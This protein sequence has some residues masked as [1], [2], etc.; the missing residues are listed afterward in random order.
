VITGNT[1]TSAELEALVEV[2][3]RLLKDKGWF[4]IYREPPP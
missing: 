2:P 4:K 3:E 1:G